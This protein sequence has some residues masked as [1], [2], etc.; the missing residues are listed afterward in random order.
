MKNLAVVQAFESAQFPLEDLGNG[1]SSFDRVIR[2]T[3][4]LPEVDRI[5]L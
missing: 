3:L 2:F 4:S 1:E 5:R